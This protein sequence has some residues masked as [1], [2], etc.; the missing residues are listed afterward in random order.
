[1]TKTL[2]SSD[3]INHIKLQSPAGYVL[4]FAVVDGDQQNVWMK[5]K[6]TDWESCP[7]EEVWDLWQHLLTLGWKQEHL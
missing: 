7:T 5:S 4:R 6:Y 1:M 2:S 3:L